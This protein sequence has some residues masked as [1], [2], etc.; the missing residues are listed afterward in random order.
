MLEF[1]LY[2]PTTIYKVI[3]SFLIFLSLIP[4]I[5]LSFYFQLLLP[6]FS[7]LF[8]NIDMDR[9]TGRNNSGQSQ[10]GPT[11]GNADIL[12]IIQNMAENQQK[13]TELLWQG[14]ITAPKEQRPGNVSNFR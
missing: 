7:H 2:N 1:W 4:K 10:N 8:T 6:I 11:G 13:Q 5:Y 14:L 9:R 12:R 3:Y